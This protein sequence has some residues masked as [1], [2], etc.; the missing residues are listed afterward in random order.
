MRMRKIEHSDTIKQMYQDHVAIDFPS[1]ERPSLSIFAE[2]IAQSA[3]ALYIFEK[4]GQDVAYTVLREDD[5]YILLN[6]LAVY[7]NQRGKGIGS[8][9]LHEIATFYHNKKGI[10]LEAEHI[11]YATTPA[12]ATLRQKRVAFYERCGYICLIP[13][14]LLL[15]DVHYHIMVKPLTENKTSDHAYLYNVL[16]HMYHHIPHPAQAIQWVNQGK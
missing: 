3:S 4:D 13:F 14:D 1:S 9:F 7:E 16:R 12:D 6:F 15:F 11:A 10:L 2:M 5:G 8:E